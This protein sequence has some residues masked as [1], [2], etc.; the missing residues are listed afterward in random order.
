M[1]TFQSGKGRE[2]IV[3]SRKG[4]SGGSPCQENFKIQNVYRCVFI[5]T[6]ARFWLKISVSFISIFEE[7]D[8]IFLQF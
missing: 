6:C 5:A 8:L 2:G 7:I 1:G 3:P 4:D